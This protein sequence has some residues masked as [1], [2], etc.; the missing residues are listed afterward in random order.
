MGECSGAVGAGSRFGELAAYP[1]D[2]KARGVRLPLLVGVG[3]GGFPLLLGCGVATRLVSSYYGAS[4][5]LYWVA[6]TGGHIGRR[7][8]NGFLNVNW[9]LVENFLAV[10]SPRVS[11]WIQVCGV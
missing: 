2:P 6:G 9:G 3:Y 10:N 1:T 8:L 7:G 11:G 4:Y 5:Q